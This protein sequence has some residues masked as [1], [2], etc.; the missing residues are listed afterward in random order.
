MRKLLPDWL[1]RSPWLHVSLFTFVGLLLF[2]SS[3]DLLLPQLSKRQ[4][5]QLTIALGT[6]VAA[7][8][9]ALVL[10]RLQRM[11]RRVLALES[12]SRKNAEEELGRLFDLSLDL[13]CVVDFDSRLRRLNPAWEAVL[14]H[15]GD[16]TLS[17]PLM[18]Y[19]HPDDRPATELQV[20]HLLDGGSMGSFENRMRCGDGSYRWVHWNAAP[21]PGQRLFFA[22]GRDV[23]E[24]KRLTA[25]LQKA[26]EAA[27]VA[28]QETERKNEEL[29]GKVA[30][31]GRMNERLIASQRQAD[32]IFSA[33]AQ[34]L[35]GT[36][37][38]GK[39]RLD[40]QI[41]FGGFGT[42][43][44]GTH[45]ALD[46]Q[47]AVKVFR[48]T[49]GNDAA[50]AVER[51]RLE[52]ISAARLSHPNAIRVLDS[53]V[54]ADGIAYLVMELLQGH[55]L[56]EELRQRKYLP[57]RRCFKIAESVCAA[58]GEAHELGIIHRDIKPQNVFLHQAPE[59]E[60]V[61]VLDFGIAKLR[62]DDAAEDQA[63]LTA[64]GLLIGTPLY[65]APE[66]LSNKPYD[67]RSD[68]YSVGVMLYEMLCG[69]V[70]FP[71]GS[72][73][74]LGVVRGHLESTPPPLRL[75]TSVVAAFVEAVALRAL[76]KDPDRRPTAREFAAALA[77]ASTWELEEIVPFS[78]GSELGSKGSETVDFS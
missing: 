48:P 43:Y 49:A 47:I 68:V 58:L 3:K 21:L 76:A 19:V 7:V 33:L 61:K 39:Y 72:L 74:L 32:R 54:S 78:D 36:V 65:M 77:T 34:A 2:E 44:R 5:H 26:K 23:T 35:P 75:P 6:V 20:R 56:A 46:R 24:R 50:I 40:E 18:G 66:R 8:G 10:S 16:G 37:L 60:V 42:V 55:S 31:L 62:A 25:E 51:F 53:G 9:G 30:E 22:T 59:G 13:V 67:G 17:T 4:D 38:E 69:T 71:A 63:G 45:L 29:G 28:S 14:G 11:H 27:E 70:P 52:G 12:A 57:P 15:T 73:G 64:T 41:G 1:R